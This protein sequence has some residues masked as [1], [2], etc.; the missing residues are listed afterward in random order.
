V[1]YRRFDER[2]AAVEEH[3]GSQINTTRYLYDPVGELRT[4]VDAKG[5]E[6]AVDYDRLGRRTQLRSPDSGTTSFEYDD[7]GNLVSRQTA[8]L[9]AARQFVTYEYDFN[10]LISVHYPA[11][12]ELKYEYGPP[13]APE[14]GA[15]RVV[16]VVDDAGFESRGYGRLGEVVRS[17]RTVKPLKPND[18]PR[19]FE[20]RFSFDPFG[21]MLSLTYPDGERLDYTYDG[22]GLVSRAVG[23][24]P[25]TKHYDA[26]TEVYVDALTYDEFGKRR[27][28]RLG[29]GA[30]TTWA[31]EPDTQRL[32]HVHTDARG[33]LLQE[34]TY[35]Y[36]LVGNV[37]TMV[38]E[39][40]EPTGSRS[41]AVSYT[42]DYDDL[43]RLTTATGTAKARPGVVDQFKATYEFDEIHNLTQLDQTHWLTTANDLGNDTAYPPHTN[44]HFAYSFGAAG[45]HQATKIGDQNFVYDANGNTLRE[46]RDHG[47]PTCAANADHLRRYFWGEDNEMLAV[48]DG[49]GSNVTRF[50]YDAD[51]QRVVKLGRGGESITIGQFFALKGR[52]AA[53]KHVFVGETRV[54]S[55]LLPPPGWDTDWS[56]GTSPSGPIV[57]TAVSSTSG[58]N[59]NGCDPSNYQPQKCPI[60][61]SPDPVIDRRLTDTMVRPE[62]YYYHSDQVGSTTWV[63]DQNGRVH[64]HV[65]YFP[66]GEVWRDP[67]SDS[68]GAPVKRQQFL[69]TSKEFDEE[70][71][72]YY[73]GARYLDPVRARWVSP[74]PAL[75]SYLPSGTDENLP[76]IGGIY[77]PLN[78]S[79]FAYAFFNP[80]RLRDADGRETVGELIQRKGVESAGS[81]SS[82]A[83]FG[84]AFAEAAWGFFGAEAVSRVTDSFVNNKQVSGGDIFFAAV[85]VGSAGL[86]ASSAAKA[87]LPKAARL[88]GGVVDRLAKVFRAAEEGNY[89]YRAVNA[90]GKTIYVG[91]TNDFARRAAE[92]L[93]KRGLQIEK[94]MS[95]LSR[96]DARAV[97]AGA[98]RGSRTGK[99]R[100]YVAEQ[101][102]QHREE[103]PDIR[104]GDQAGIRAAQ[105]D[106]IQVMARRAKPG[107]VLEVVAPDGGVI[108]LHYLGKHPEYGD[109]IAVAPGKRARR[110]AVSADLFRDAYVTFYPA[111]SAVARGFATVVGQLPSR[112]LPGRMRRAGAR[113]GTRVATWI[114]EDG[115]REVL[116][117]ALSD[118]ER[119]LPIAAV[120][121]HEFLIQRVS[122][123][124]RPERE[125]TASDR[126][127]EPERGAAA[128]GADGPRT[129]IH[130]AYFADK[131]AAGE[132]AQ[133]LRAQ[134]FETE[135]RLGADGVN[136]LVLAKHGI[137]VSEET[138]AAAR[139]AIEPLVVRR[140]GE[141]D[142]WEVDTAGDR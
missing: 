92:H 7:M 137:I 49:G 17:T 96:A 75:I 19:T 63:T 3:A 82:V 127:E 136:W 103:E 5:N 11:S 124:W 43:Y 116:K 125:G 35:T 1:L 42:F 135:E 60:N 26:A 138:V 112:G 68:D 128:G 36:D 33:R 13:G 72:L 6:T 108:Y 44:H 79:P 15:G 118:E 111:V 88:L 57:Q 61:P 41:G 32:H 51:G 104:R 69:F 80:V 29:N 37:K 87:A 90:A 4:I 28:V 47:D 97:E 105:V 99:E 48:I 54:A 106:W 45:P 84:W 53:T 139:G 140:G 18:S 100:R 93:S 130:Y 131:N 27:S 129:I 133:Q 77:Q 76:G 40:G 24:R 71:G 102:Q 134:G 66:Y 16:R 109:A 12:T 52:K 64:E 58:T 34:L 30:A 91:I 117:E 70:T 21:R 132:V 14:N 65:D 62:T 120:W 94:L 115:S 59:T 85:E 20:T 10:Q 38:N 83:T 56:Q 142:G 73:F 110:A 113:E 107:D 114:I 46:C 8:N 86:G 121:N 126:K 25:A 22:G 31:Y 55:K 101:D 119:R 81:G 98:H 50:I 67:Q 95:N 9:R 23:N 2:L 122:E 39:L 78:L 74:D 89:V 141:Y 123:G